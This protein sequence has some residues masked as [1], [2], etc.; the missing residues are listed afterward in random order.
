MRWVTKA[1]GWWDASVKTCG[2][3]G[4]P[5]FRI[6][7]EPISEDISAP[8]YHSQIGIM[9]KPP[10]HFSQMKGT[11]RT[12]VWLDTFSTRE[13]QPL[14]R[15]GTGFRETTE[16]ILRAER[17]PKRIDITYIRPTQY[18]G[19]SPSSNDPREK[20]RCSRDAQRILP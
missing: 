10:I 5:R 17:R 9:R 13:G 7:L 16:F 12:V 15:L 14:G 8:A 3:A 18:L 2:T 1:R 11:V 4:E 6:V 19:P 20:E